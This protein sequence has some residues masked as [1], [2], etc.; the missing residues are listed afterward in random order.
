LRQQDPEQLKSLENYITSAETQDVE[1]ETEAHKASIADQ[2]QD[3]VT[4]SKEMP[5]DL[6]DG[7]LDAEKLQRDIRL[8][9]RKVPSSVAVIT[10][11]SYDFELMQNVPMGV[12]VSSL[13][14][15]SLDPPT[16]SFN[17]KAPS[18]TLDAIRAAKGLFRVHFPAADRGGANMVD[19]FSR[20]N[21][22]TAYNMRKKTLKIYVPGHG[23]PADKLRRSASGA[24]QILGDSTRAVMECS[25][26]QEMSVADHVIL[27]A[28]VNGLESRNPQA[29]T[30]L[31]VDGSYMRPDGSKVTFPRNPVTTEDTWP[32]WELP[33]FPGEKERLEYLEHIRSTIKADPKMLQPGYAGRR[34]LELKLPMSPGEWGIN[35]EQLIDECRREAGEK[36]QLPPALQGTPV[37]SDFYGR[38]TPSDRAK[39]I[40]RAK[41]L[42]RADARC[43]SL[44]FRHF[45][46]QLG[47][48]PAS[49]DLLP[50]DL[51]EPLRAE[52]L[53]GPFVPR[54][55][56]FE[57][58]KKELDLQYLEQAE[59]HLVQQLAGIGHQVAVRSSFAQ[60]L[61]DLGEPKS[62]ATHFKRS[63]ARFLAAATPRLFDSNQIDIAG[64]VSPAQA[65][66]VMRRLLRY[67]HLERLNLTTFRKNI[68]L[69]YHE[70][71][72]LIKVHPCISGF[73]VEFFLGKLRHM[74]F[75]SHSRDLA[76][77]VQTMIAP[78]FTSVV[79]WADLQ[80]RVQKLVQEMPR[81][82]MSWPKLDKLA[83]MG[84]ASEAVLQ[85][86]GSTDKQALWTGAIIDTLVA[87]ELKALYGRHSEPRINAAIGRH[88]EE[89]YN[90][91]VHDQ[92]RALRDSED[93]RDSAEFMDQAMKASLNVD[94]L[95]KQRSP[96][97]AAGEDSGM[98]ALRTW[99]KHSSK[100]I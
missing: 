92:P 33:L 4:D 27:V 24:P 54:T 56:R 100:D 23:S 53:L 46:Q 50:S 37:L 17:I 91:K 86:P 74:Y 84:L 82:A 10:V 13:S 71:L 61:D 45:L 38:L 97:D 25:L 65:R 36:S 67:L 39:I 73:D 62:V 28:R 72:R 69:D 2:A 51:A 34:Q 66:V 32:I 42:V 77:Q 1:R 98:E 93:A 9:M 43:L 59:N 79:S 63:R 29:R 96:V 44:N 90:Y 60:I 18:K 41:K 40:E 12:A 47:V 30:I 64:E 68:N 22:P 87:K 55:D 88:L 81:Q 76:E 3:T 11:L 78:F 8:L 35:T 94:V 52:G 57:E 26:T 95:A 6:D 20:G 19:S 48:H 7:D 75:T 80:Q 16:I 31:Y 5:G 15:V 14:T 21:H 89:Q 49:R 70:S 83:A 58:E 99:S 85:V